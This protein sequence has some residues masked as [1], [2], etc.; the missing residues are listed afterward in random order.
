MEGPAQLEEMMFTIRRLLNWL[1]LF[2]LV[3]F[4]FPY[5]QHTTIQGVSEKKFTLGVPFSPWLIASWKEAEDR[6][7]KNEDGTI[8]TVHS[9]DFSFAVNVEVISWSSLLGI[10]GSV[11]LEASRRLRPKITSVPQTTQPDVD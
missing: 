8:R 5:F 11:L 7:E 4:F 6:I 3:G 2:C 1:A 9:G 10:A